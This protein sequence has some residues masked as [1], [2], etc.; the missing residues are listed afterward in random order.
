MI[1][2]HHY[3]ITGIGTD[4]GKTLVSAIFC[5]GLQAN[6]YKPI[7]AGSLATTDAHTV[8]NLVTKPITFYKSTYRF[9]LGAS[10][11]LAA[12]E[13]NV[14]INLDEINTPNTTNNLI[15]EGAGGLLVPI[16]NTQTILDI[17]K[18]LHLPVV[19]VSQHYLGSINHT[20]LSYELLKANNITIA[21]IVF[22]G[23]S[24]P[25]T[26]NF[27]LNYTGLNCLLRIQLHAHI[28][29]DVVSKYANELM[30]NLNR[31]AK[32]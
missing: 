31:V 32:L 22:N 21:G 14:V 15:I 5:E 27:I 19:L 2:L 8:Q 26:E 20:L 3:F 9:K 7:Q 23:E 6:Y 28:T 24:N 12:Q 4:V 25:S 30:L 1:N 29:K 17:I 13:E 11:H 16:N 10:P 18:K